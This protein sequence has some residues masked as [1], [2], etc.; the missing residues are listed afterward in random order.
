MSQTTICEL[1]LHDA[2]N[3]Y[4]KAIA[5]FVLSEVVLLR[6]YFNQSADLRYLSRVA[7]L[8]KHD[9]VFDGLERSIHHRAL[10]ETRLREV[11]SFF[12]FQC[13]QKQ[14]TLDLVSVGNQRNV[15]LVPDMVLLVLALKVV[16]VDTLL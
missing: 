11:L 5:W 8:D 6:L 4:T 9:M 2:Q 1:T 12:S 3:F 7:Y 16:V 10:F 15:N 14:L 13:H